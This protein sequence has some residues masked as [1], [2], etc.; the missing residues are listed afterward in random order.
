M[1]FGH[2]VS[3]AVRRA[4]TAV[5]LPS[6]AAGGTRSDRALDVATSTDPSADERAKAELREMV[7]G[8]QRCM[9]AG[10]FDG[11]TLIHGCRKVLNLW[12]GGGGSSLHDA[13]IG[14]TGIES[15]TGH[16]LG[17]SHVAIGRDVDHVRF[18]PGSPTEEAEV[19]EILH[20]F[21]DQFGR[22][23]HNLALFLDSD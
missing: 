12:V 21:K 4:I 10:S 16:V 11:A 15:Q 6:G 14:F 8:L 20:F 3:N 18:E 1:R 7:A 23:L 13:I 17:G 9:A 22:E 19:E 2:A 5:G